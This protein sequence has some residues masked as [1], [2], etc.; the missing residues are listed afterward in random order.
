M[1]RTLKRIKLIKLQ[2]FLCKRVYVST[3]YL[4]FSILI[5]HTYLGSRYLP[6]CL[7]SHICIDYII[8]LTNENHT[9]I[10]YASVEFRSNAN[11]K[12]EHSPHVFYGRYKYSEQF[13][14]WFTS[15]ALDAIG[16]RTH[17]T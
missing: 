17:S 16:K 14:F 11:E 12:N 3:E 7:C 9:I 6:N 13:Y 2:N 1:S 10:L 8:K 4:F 15:V 5:L